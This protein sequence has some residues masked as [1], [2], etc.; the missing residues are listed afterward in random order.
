VNE[1]L[2]TMSEGL[3]STNEELETINDE[4]QQRTDEL[5][6]VNGFLE[7]VLGSLAAAVVVVDGELRVTAW[8]EEARNLWGLHSQEAQGQHLLNLDIGLPVEKLRAPIRDV[9]AGKGAETLEL[10]AVN[11]RGKPTRV[12]LRF[13]PLAG[14]G[15]EVRGAIVMMEASDG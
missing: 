9:L 8:N 2:E 5:H 7:A 12:V 6:D 4:L 15:D 1:E 13:A 10:D 11:R 3:Q 14:I